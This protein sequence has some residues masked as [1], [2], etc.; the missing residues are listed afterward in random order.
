M[1]NPGK[2]PRKVKKL[3]NEEKRDITYEAMMAE[4][5]ANLMDKLTIHLK[6]K[7]PN[8]KEFVRLIKSKEIII[9]SGFPGTGKTYVACAAALDMLKHDPKIKKIVLVKSV[10]TIEDEEIGYLKGTME[11]KMKPFMY[12]FIHN[13]EKIIGKQ[14]VESLRQAGIIEEMP[15]AYIRGINIDEAIVIIDEAQNIT[16]KKAKSIMTRL[17]ENSKMIFLG[18]TEQI[19]LKGAKVK[20]SSLDFMVRRFKDKEDFG[21]IAFGEEDIVRHRLIKTI[22][23][24]FDET[25]EA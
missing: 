22:L 23:E 16:K 21:T 20:E 2:S 1:A 17:G 15:L 4:P 13:F 12:S 11:E 14:W 8:Q 19:D 7:T 9:C 6:C 5:V 25:L 24:G 3:T 18:D 10:T